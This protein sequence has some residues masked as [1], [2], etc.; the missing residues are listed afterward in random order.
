M[1]Y[2][3]HP[4][5]MTGRSYVAMNSFRLS[6]WLWVETCS[7]ETT[8]PWI[9]STSRPAPT[10]AFAYRSTLWGV[11]DAHDTTSPSLISRI[12]CSTRSS[13]TGSRY[14]SCIRA[15]AFSSGRDAISS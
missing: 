13:L 2:E 1:V 11:S 8:V 14:S 9:T 12:R 4:P 6:G 5:T 7:A 15:V 3:A 10:T